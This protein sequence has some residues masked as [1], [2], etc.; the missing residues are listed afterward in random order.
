MWF[1]LIIGPILGAFIGWI[2][3]WAAIKLIFRP[4]KAIRIPLINYSIQ[5]VIPKRRQEIACSVGNVVANQLLSL[6]DLISH[7]NLPENQQKA[8]EILSGSV[9]NH[10]N[11]RLLLFL[12]L[13]LRNSILQIIDDI[14]RRES[15]LLLAKISKDLAAELSSSLNLSLLV[16]DKINRLDLEQLEHL[17]LSV[18]SKE[19]KHIEVLG[20]IIGFFIGL[21]QA[22]LFLLL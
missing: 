1:V 17:V 13:P 15:P 4:Y 3:N 19:L 6:E 5:G 16:Q 22:L 12:P 21:F 2:T 14:L 11:E 10:L 20:A 7:I 8:V 9:K 18:A